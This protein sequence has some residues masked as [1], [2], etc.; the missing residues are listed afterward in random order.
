MPT[1]IPRRWLRGMFVVLRSMMMDLGL[2]ASRQRNWIE[3]RLHLATAPINLC[4]DLA[5][6]Q[7]VMKMCFQKWTLLSISLSLSL[8]CLLINPI[9]RRR[10]LCLF[11]RP[12]FSLLYRTFLL[13]RYTII[14]SR[15]ADFVISYRT[16]NSWFGRLIAL[17]RLNMTISRVLRDNLVICTCHWPEHPLLR[18]A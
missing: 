12:S 15:T 13:C 6:S 7:I 16:G 1:H 2:W 9:I 8:C 17:I 11:G 10:P 3:S 4:F 18:S 5:W 14:S